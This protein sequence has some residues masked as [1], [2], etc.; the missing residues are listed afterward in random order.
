MIPAPL[1]AP[2]A[3]A[4]RAH[5]TP[6]AQPAPPSAS[7]P[8]DPPLR[9]RAEIAAR[10]DQLR[11]K[12]ATANEAD[13]LAIREQGRTLQALANVIDAVN[14]PNRD[15]RGRAFQEAI[16]DVIKAAQRQVRAFVQ[17]LRGIFGDVNATPEAN[18]TGGVAYN[19]AANRLEVSWN[20]VHNSAGTA[21]TDALK[22]G[23]T[24]EQAREAATGKVRAILDQAL[25]HAAEV[26]AKSGGENAADRE[27]R[28]APDPQ[29]GLR[30]PTPAEKAR[31]EIGANLVE[32]PRHVLRAYLEGRTP[33]EIGA[34]LGLTPEQGAHAAKRVTMHVGNLLRERGFSEGEI[35]AALKPRS[36]RSDETSRD[37]GMPGEDRQMAGSEPATPKPSAVATAR[38]AIGANLVERPRYVLRSYL[39]GKTPEEIGAALGLTP[40]Q[41]AHAVKRVAMHVGNLL[42]ERGFSEAEIADAVKPRSP[43]PNAPG[44]S[45]L[46]PSAAERIRDEIAANLVER[47]RQILQA[48]LNGQ[49]PEEIGAQ[50]GLTP[51]QARIASDNVAKHVANLMRERGISAEDAGNAVNARTA[52][53]RACAP[54]ASE[55]LASSQPPEPSS[56]KSQPVAQNSEPAPATV[57]PKKETSPTAPTAPNTE[58]AAG[59]NRDAD[60]R[61][62]TD[63]PYRS[64]SD[65]TR[66]MIGGY[67]TRGTPWEG[68]IKWLQGG[69]FP[70]PVI[71]RLVP[72]RRM[73]ADITAVTGN[74]VALVRLKDGSRVLRMGKGDKLPPKDIVR[75]IAHTHPSGELFFSRED[76]QKF[77]TN[78][79]NPKSSVLTDPA[80]GFATRLHMSKWISE[81]HLWGL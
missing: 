8:K 72:I 75:M 61:P 40:E 74:E 18:G 23:A 13:K 17:K 73:M 76:A 9:N 39:A 26:R 62:G 11:H 66:P 29:Q 67:S 20:E 43:Q 69:D 30:E 45:S 41:A 59:T 12:I 47:P 36:T 79:K 71:P 56:E 19:K 28:H 15:A 10:Y 50:L 14:E 58:I 25:R 4:A 68:V 70:M 60:Q 35:S 37:S 16:P 49:T 5:A 42:R 32:R 55:P 78:P 1:P 38:D 80:D 3:K 54:A 6:A 27:T 63:T 53:E 7:A 57:E 44:S 51:E 22:A 77:L 81:K 31:D 64:L 33:E 2:K 21:Y 34:A 65:G 48:R 46:Q 52:M 24:V